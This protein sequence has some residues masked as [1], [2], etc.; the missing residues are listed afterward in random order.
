MSQMDLFMVVL[1]AVCGVYAVLGVLWWVRDRAD[2][3]AVA[4]LDAM[5]IDPYHAVATAD[6]DRGADR[7]GAAELLL[8]GLIRI[9][10]DGQVAVTARGADP[11]RTPEHPVPAAVLAT[12]RGHAGPWPL[13]YLYVDTEHCGRRDPFLRGE[14][15][16]WPRWSTRDR[17]RVR[18][19]A[20]LTAVLLA[21][22]CAAQLLYA[23]GAFSGPGDEVVAAVFVGLL[24]WGAFAL[25]LGVIVLI[26]WPWR[27]DWF[28]EYCRTLLPHPAE[29][30]LDTEQRQ[31]LHRA[32]AFS[33]PKEE[34]VEDMSWDPGAF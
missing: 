8:A 24:M 26:V 12:L 23:V 19:V 1:T 2:R 33:F 15:A 34:V 32:M 11:G 5:D 18:P 21:G 31:Q 25:V 9:E 3:A 10:E 4:R 30:A 17:D 14:D 27:R 13:G 20:I 29:D 6:G 16:R 22:W 28:A 7:A